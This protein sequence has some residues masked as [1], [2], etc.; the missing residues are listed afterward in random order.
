MRLPF[1]ISLPHCS[2]EI[3][4]LIGR[5]LALTRDERD[6]SIDT[7]TREAF[8]SLQAAKIMCA[9]WSRLVVDLNRGP[10]QRGI[11]GVVPRVDYY[12]RSIY[13][14]G[15]APDEEGINDRLVEYYWPYHHRLKEAMA[16]PDIKGLIDCH[17]LSGIGPP[18]APDAG[19]KRKDIVL[20]NNGDLR[21]QMV[22]VRGRT[23][24]PK[25]ILRAMRRAFLGRGLSVSLNDP[26]S[27]GFISTHYG[28]KYADRGKIAVQIEINQDLYLKPGTKKIMPERLE[29]LKA[30]LLGCLD[31]IAGMI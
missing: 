19:R 20:G 1:I 24:C 25:D 15:M 16:L 7:G 9:R 13:N 2:G 17:S 5:S 22:P 21:G 30:K 3:P 14:S 10:D 23:T 31:E 27:G 28:H 26:Y 11:K 29:G 12:G 6:E 18:E 8:G 4:D